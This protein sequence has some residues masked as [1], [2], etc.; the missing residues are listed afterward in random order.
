[1]YVIVQ[2]EFIFCFAS[3]FTVRL[4]ALFEAHMKRSI[5]T[6]RVTQQL[7]LLNAFIY[8]YVLYLHECGY[9]C[10][11]H[12]YVKQLFWLSCTFFVVLTA[13]VANPYACT[14]PA[15][16]VHECKCG[17][18]KYGIIYKKLKFE[19]NLA[20]FKDM[21]IN[22]VCVAFILYNILLFDSYF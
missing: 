6:L 9:K 21:T 19:L 7:F 1:M 11:L 2:I 18:S 3:I 10:I 20:Q 14:K 16:V 5:C 15:Y 22:W 4:L 8:I 12:M 13:C 17:W